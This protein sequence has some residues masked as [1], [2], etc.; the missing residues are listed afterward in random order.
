MGIFL[1][2]PLEDVKGFIEF[3]GKESLYVGYWKVYSKLEEKL[4]LFQKYD[5][6]QSR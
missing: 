6:A 3:N 2:Y 5:E 4:A 1:G